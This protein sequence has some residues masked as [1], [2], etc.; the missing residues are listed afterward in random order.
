MASL[1]Q[2][3]W[4][5]VDSRSW[6]WTGRPRVLLFIGSQRVGHNWATELS[7][8]ELL[9]NIVVVFAIYWHESAIGVMCPSSGIPLPPPSPSD[10]QGCP[11]ALALSA[12]FHASN[13]DWWS[14][15]HMAIYMFQCCSLKSSHPCLLPQNPKSVLCIC[16]SC[17][18]AYRVIVAI[19]LNSIY[20]H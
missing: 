16:V 8:T 7:W 6:W 17:C 2:C 13:L 20:M 1:T 4:V 14:V 18:L 11:S 12:L 3:T 15:S 9:Y 19:F 5:C 10:P